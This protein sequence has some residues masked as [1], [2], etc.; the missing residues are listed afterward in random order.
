MNTS[1]GV[2]TDFDI[3]GLNSGFDA[4]SGP[5]FNFDDSMD[6]AP[7]VTP[8]IIINGRFLT[9]QVSGVQAF[10]RSVCRELKM[11]TPLKIVV[12]ENEQVI[13]EEFSDSIIRYGKLRGHVW[14]QFEL[15][16]FI[17][18]HPDATLLNL[19]NTGPVN[20]RNQLV[21][22]HDLA[23][24][25]HPEWFRWIFGTYYKFLIPKICRNSKAILTVSETIKSE[26]IEY[27]GLAREKITV[28]PNK[29]GVPFLDA[30]PVAPANFPYKKDEF[31][32][33]V[34]TN[35]PRKNFDLVMPLFKEDF[36]GKKLV[37][38]GGNHK[39]FRAPSGGEFGSKAIMRT[40][41]VRDPEL[42]WLYKNA[43][44]LI[45]PSF[46][47]GFGIPNI[48]AFSQ[49]CGVICSELRVFKEVCKN[50]AWYFNPRSSESLKITLE[51]YIENYGRGG[52]EISKGKV[53]FEELQTK[54]R[55]SIILNAFT[56]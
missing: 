4:M 18:K 32:L 10:A 6:L 2:S 15:P 29:V 16:S 55:S 3:K 51:N 38:A 42:K 17:K 7:G 44:G 22:I 8:Q 21:T 26:L 19:C 45:N 30:V 47:E 27:L 37:I 25:H 20:V 36:Q 46:Y 56:K 40:G 49:G 1:R 11:L 28:V 24:L 33:I 13:D 34:G 54:N 12:S 52:Q 35:D 41:Y 31:F 53:I 5:L 23:F 9:Q 43:I 48:E 14:E 50:A 39:N